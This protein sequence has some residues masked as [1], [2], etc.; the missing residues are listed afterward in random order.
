[1]RKNKIVK[2]KLKNNIYYDNSY[3]PN[4][5]SDKWY[6]YKNNNKDRCIRMKL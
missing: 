4:N 6:H 3:Y 1:M 5:D 2:L